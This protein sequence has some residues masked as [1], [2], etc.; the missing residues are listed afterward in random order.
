M[1]NNNT[2]LSKKSK[3]EGITIPNFRTITM[4]Q[5]GTGTKTDIKTSRTEDTDLNPCSYAHLI[6]AKNAKNI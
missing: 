2:L 5:H 6:F 3:T 4:K 1:A